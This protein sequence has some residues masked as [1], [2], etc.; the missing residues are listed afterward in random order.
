MK[1]RRPFLIISCCWLILAGCQSSRPE[2]EVIRPQNVKLISATT[3]VEPALNVS[4]LTFDAG[5]ESRSVRQVFTPVRS[6]E[7]LYL[8]YVLK[9]T[10]LDSGHWGAVRVVPRLDPTAELLVSAEILVSDGVALSLAV[11]VWDSAGNVWIDRTYQDW[12]MDHGYGFDADNPVEPFQ[13]LFNELANDIYLE[14]MKRSERDLAVLLDTS[15]LRY[16]LA[17]SPQA[18]TGYLSTNEAGIVE[19][20]SLPARNDPL[21]ARV[22]KIRESE[23]AFIDTIDAQYQH[24]Y[25]KMQRVYSYWRRYSYELTTYNDK[26]ERKGATRSTEGSWAAMADVYRT[27]KESKLNEDELRELAGSFDSEITPTVTELEGTVINLD[28][29]LVSQYETWRSLLR[30]IYAA[31]RGS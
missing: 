2:A 14:S 31:E 5:A 26:I 18:F 9:E 7:A 4:V 10:L 8:P 11:H 17:L 29:S 24:F 12:A 28:G 25:H 20:S 30:K 19:M 6:A 27:Y 23:Y 1:I 3:P 21:Y 15:M 13:D 22:K 16:A